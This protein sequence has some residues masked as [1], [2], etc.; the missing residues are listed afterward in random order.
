MCTRDPTEVSVCV[1]G[2]QCLCVTV[3]PP[4]WGGS[5]PWAVLCPVEGASLVCPGGGAT[6]GMR[7]GPSSMVQG[8]E[9]EAGLTSRERAGGQKGGGMARDPR[10]PA[11]AKRCL[12]PDVDECHVFSHLCPHGECINGLGS[13]RCHCQDG[14]MPDATATACLGESPDPHPLCIASGLHFCEKTR[15]RNDRVHMDHKAENIH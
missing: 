1:T 5:V 4:K 8:G 13:F 7:C 11:P 9:V 14:Y 15:T 12:S 6:H 10:Q 2:V 3:L